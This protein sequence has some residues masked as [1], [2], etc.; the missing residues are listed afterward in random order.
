MLRG[1]DSLDSSSNE[2]HPN[3]RWQKNLEIEIKPEFILSLQKKKFCNNYQKLSNN[4]M[5][6]QKSIVFQQ[7]SPGNIDLLVI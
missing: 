6:D 2:L 5:L 4:T 3:I 7:V 1:A